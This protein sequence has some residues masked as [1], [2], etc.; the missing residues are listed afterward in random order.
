LDRVGAQP[1]GILSAE[2][3][4]ETVN[5]FGNEEPQNETKIV[6]NARHDESPIGE[7]GG[8]IEMPIIV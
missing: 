2:A 4:L 7:G 5:N 1:G 8:S 3:S 6:W